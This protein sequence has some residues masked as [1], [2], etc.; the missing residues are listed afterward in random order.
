LAFF[1]TSVSSSITSSPIRSVSSSSSGAGGLWLVR[2]ALAPIAFM[3]SSWRVTARRLKAAPSAPRSWCRQ[4]PWMG[5]RAP[6]SK[7]PLSGSKRIARMPNTV[8]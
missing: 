3:I 2:M 5:T 6:L 7:K 4:T 8:S 1:Q